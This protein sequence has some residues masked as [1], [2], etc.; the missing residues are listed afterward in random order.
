ME[1][2]ATNKDAEYEAVIT[3]LE[4]AVEIGIHSLC[5]HSDSK[6]VVNQILG[7][8]QTRSERLTEYLWKVKSFLG[9]LEH[10]IIKHIPREEN[11]EAD[12]L[13][14]Q[15]SIEEE[16]IQGI[17]P[18]RNQAKP[19]FEETYEIVLTEEEETLDNAFLTYLNHNILPTGRNERQQLLR[20]ASRYTVQ[21]GILY[22]RGF[23]NPL[24]RCVAGKEA[25]EILHNTHQGS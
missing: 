21:D 16:S 9:E 14:K 13:A 18:V 8:F 2:P 20:K 11:H 25:K 5:L 6:L 4:I 24:L 22:R 1:F 23:F 3:G 19:R 12:S 10:H 17:I 15:A 7:D